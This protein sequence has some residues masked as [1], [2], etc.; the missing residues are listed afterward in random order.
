MWSIAGT[1][2]ASELFEG[3]VIAGWPN[4]ITDCHYLWHVGILIPCVYIPSRFANLEAIPWRVS[5]LE[6]DIYSSDHHGS[7]DDLSTEPW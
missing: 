6:V 1:V 2:D 4:S 7:G 3:Y 5:D